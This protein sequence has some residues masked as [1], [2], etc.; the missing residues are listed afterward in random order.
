MV[1]DPAVKAL[2][3]EGTRFD[4]CYVQTPAVLAGARNFQ[5]VGWA[6]RRDWKVAKSKA[7]ERVLRAIGINTHR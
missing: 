4:L 7:G 1:T 3:L 5:L 2:A 6:I